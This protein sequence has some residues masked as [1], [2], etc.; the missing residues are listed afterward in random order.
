MPITHRLAAAG[1]SLIGLIGLVV[2]ASAGSGR[3]PE[4]KTGRPVVVELY[5]SQGCSSCPPADALLGQLA[6]RKDVLAISLPV[7]YWDMLGWKDT[8]ASD[9]NTRRQKAYDRVLGRG[10]IYTPQM[11]VDGINDVIGS[12]EKAVE[13]AIAARTAD[14]EA[15]PLNVDADRRQI[16]ITIGPAPDRGEQD[17]TIWMF[18]I[19]PKVTVNIGDG[20]N[21]GR[22]ITYRNVVRE[23]RAVGI[24]KGQ[25]VALDLPRSE[26][27]S[28]GERIAVIVQQ[29]GY[30]RIVGAALIEHSSYQFVR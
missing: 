20:E 14:M 9:A 23:I 24:W 27:A 1:L 25:P 29:G 7:T 10:G 11:I 13:S 18:R 19:L 8:L 12:R 21:G 5:T 28:P 26:G 3:A 22:T 15:I 30:G 6:A 4:S 2:P 16:H 17:A